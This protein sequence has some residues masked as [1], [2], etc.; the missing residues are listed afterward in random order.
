MLLRKLN[1]IFILHTVISATIEV[2]IHA[3]NKRAEVQFL[4][5]LC[6]GVSTMHPNIILLLQQQSF[7]RYFQHNVE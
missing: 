7:G 6:N 2:Q 1:T 3:K 4:V 5:A